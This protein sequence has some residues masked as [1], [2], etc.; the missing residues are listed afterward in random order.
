MIPEANEE[1]ALDEAA[2]AVTLKTREPLNKDVEDPTV[3]SIQQSK[4][5]TEEDHR[6]SLAEKKKDGERVKVNAL[7]GEFNALVERNT[8]AEKHL[9]L[10]EDDF[11]ID[12]EYFL[13]L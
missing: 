2:L 3:Y 6:L 12:A 7:R 11:Q 13:I 9:R 1:L 8:A 5:R 10:T 4:L